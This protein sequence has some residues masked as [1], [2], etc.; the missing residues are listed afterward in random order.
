MYHSYSGS[1]ITADVSYDMF[2]S[3]SASGKAEFEI[4]IWLGALGGAGPISS[5][6]SPVDT[7]T[8]AGTTW[9]LY[10]GPN[11]STTVYSFVAESQQDSF[12]GDIIDFFYYLEWMQRFNAN[13]YLLSI[14]AGTEPFE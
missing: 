14:Q 11:G 2:T 9:N 3:S 4:M 7:P 8:L 1:A 13:Q 12:S 5:T 6:G 10:K